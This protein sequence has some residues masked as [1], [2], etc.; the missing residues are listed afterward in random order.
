MWLERLQDTNTPAATRCVGLL[1]VLHGLLPKEVCDLRLRDVRMRSR[2]LW[3]RRS[4]IAIPLDPITCGAIK[5]YI[6]ERRR[7][8]NPH[9]FVS[10]QSWRSDAPVSGVFVHDRLLHVGIP[11]ATIARQNLIRDVLDRENPVVAARVLR[12]SIQ[13]INVYLRLLGKDKALQPRMLR[14]AS[15]DRLAI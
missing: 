7:T 9:L 2:T 5:T 3:L 1:I 8:R 14:G 13:R 4:R 6:A 11:G 12:L 10:E 15:Q